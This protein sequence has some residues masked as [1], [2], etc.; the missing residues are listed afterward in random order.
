[1]AITPQSASRARSGA[2]IRA[3]RRSGDRCP[4]SLDD[5]STIT[6]SWPTAR[7]AITGG[8]FRS[9]I[10]SQA[11]WTRCDCRSRCDVSSSAGQT[12][13]GFARPC[14][15]D[16]W[17]Y[18]CRS[19]RRPGR[20]SRPKTILR[21]LE[22]GRRRV[23]TVGPRIAPHSGVAAQLWRK[24]V[25]NESVTAARVG[26]SRTLQTHRP[27]IEYSGVIGRRLLR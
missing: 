4:P 23:L 13:Y 11:R 18:G 25:D 19:D 6:S 12:A 17:P 27:V 10:L 24:R 20:V 14:R 21:P 15:C 8:C 22:L 7:S 16:R 1:L 2:Q 26:T 3:G 9:L 5:S